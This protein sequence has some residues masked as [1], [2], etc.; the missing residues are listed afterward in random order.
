[1]FSGA[2][3]SQRRDRTKQL[4]DD[5]RGQDFSFIRNNLFHSLI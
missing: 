4:E 3:S 2:G 5:E 1:M